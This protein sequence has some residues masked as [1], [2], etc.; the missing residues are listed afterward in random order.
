M[1][2]YWKS[3]QRHFCTVCRCWLSAH[4]SNIRL[5]EQAPRHQEGVPA[6]KPPVGDLVLRAEVLPPEA[7]SSSLPES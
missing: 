1:T 5:H 4:P 2:E 7:L 6:G 3:A